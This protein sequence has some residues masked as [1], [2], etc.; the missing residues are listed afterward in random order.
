LNEYNK[1]DNEDWACILKSIETAAN[2][3]IDLYSFT[4]E[5]STGLGREIKIGIIENL[6]RVAC[7]DQD[8]ASQEHEMIRKISGLFRLDHKEFINSKVKVKKEFNLDTAGL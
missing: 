3:R 8:L 6:F 1:L 2:E 4:K 7:A 5:V